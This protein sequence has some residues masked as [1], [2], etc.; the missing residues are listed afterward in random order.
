MTS[1]IQTDVNNKEILMIHLNRRNIIYILIIIFV[2]VKF[3]KS[4]FFNQ[5]FLL[6]TSFKYG[7]VNF[8]ALEK[9][10]ELIKYAHT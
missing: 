3:Y 8:R 7:C 4:F 5:N 2:F 9:T 1:K 6:N 10:C